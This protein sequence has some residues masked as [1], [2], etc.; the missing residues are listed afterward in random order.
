MNFDELI[1]GF[2]RIALRERAVGKYSHV[3]VLCDTVNQN[4]INMMETLKQTFTIQEYLSSNCSS[5][6]T[7]LEQLVKI[8]CCAVYVVLILVQNFLGTCFCG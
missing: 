3:K 8:L 5:N 2:I 6:V 4:V 1:V 7:R